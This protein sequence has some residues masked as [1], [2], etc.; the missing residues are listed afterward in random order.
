MGPEKGA[1]IALDCDPHTPLFGGRLW[2]D[3]YSKVL[4]TQPPKFCKGIVCL[5]RNPALQFFAKGSK[6]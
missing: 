3:G 6:S 5:E 4:R 1:E 2:R